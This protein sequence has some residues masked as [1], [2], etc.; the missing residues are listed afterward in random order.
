MKIEE[1]ELMMNS[2][3]L[4]EP[5]QASSLSRTQDLIAL[6]CRSHVQ[7]HHVSAMQGISGSEVSSVQV[8]KQRNESNFTVTDV[9]WNHYNSASLATSSTNGAV[10]VFDFNAGAKS[11]IQLSN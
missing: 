6:A 11:R 2:H 10:V 1:E 3:F 4:S 7:I 5:I 9:Q 8:S